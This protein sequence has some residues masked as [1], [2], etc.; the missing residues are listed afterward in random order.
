MGSSPLS[1]VP[2]SRIVIPFGGGIILG[3]SV[4]IL[5]PFVA[6]AIAIFG[7]GLLVLMNVLSRNPET[8]SKIRPF[9]IVPLTIIS[10]ALGWTAYIIHQPSPINLPKVNGMV[11][12]GRIENIEFKVHS[13]RI[14][15]NML[16]KHS[17][18]ARVLLTTNGCNYNLRAGDD[19]A[20]VAN[21]Q[22]IGNPNLGEDVDYA[23][24]LKRKG[25]IYQQH[26]ESKGIH[27]YSHHKTFGSV[28]AQFRSAIKQSVY[29]S[30][31]SPDSK[32]YI[33]ALILG[34]RQLIDPQTRIEYSY[35]GIAHVLALSGL[36]IGIIMLIA[37]FIFWP[38][39]FYKQK[40]LRY[41]L[42]VIV[43]LIYDVLTGLPP[44][45][46]RATV[47]IT[48]TFATFIFGRK[49]S[50]INALMVAAL[51]ILAYS[52]ESLFDVGF[53][54]SFITVLFILIFSPRSALVSIKK[55]WL[56]YLISLI[57]T[58]AIAMCATIALTAYYF[59][60]ISWVSVLTNTL[61]LPLFPVIMGVSAIAVVMA[62]INVDFEAL[63]HITDASLQYVSFIAQQI[64][65]IPY[66]FS[67]DVYVNEM[68]VI[69]YFACITLFFIF[70]KY[71]KWLYLNWCITCCAAGIVCH[72]LT[73][74]TFQR[75]GCVLFNSYDSTP[76]FIYQNGQSFCW[77]PD[78]NPNVFHTDEFHQ[79]H[80]GFFAAHC[81][82]NVSV[83]ND[84][85]RIPNAAF[86]SPYARV[87]GKTILVA[88]SQKWRKLPNS[89]KVVIDYCIV[90]RHFNGKISELARHY[91]IRQMVVSGNVYE[92]NI[93]SITSECKKLDIH[94]KN[95]RD[96][97][98]IIE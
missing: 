76:V 39:D 53:Q 74:N 23:K 83:A 66:S 31:L 33:I 80:S 79:L 9:T 16:S 81:I 72:A 11:A 48:F 38:L 26:I 2:F 40:K 1:K 67:K 20:F 78:D 96:K 36:H 64:S 62:C 59:H 35:A 93:A 75:K 87:F 47:M 21:F 34:D 8:R 84:S 70:V 91:I 49:S 29:K 4:N 95:L 6:I 3:N 14:I 82:E 51:I 42:S 56:N 41:I 15:T 92:P 7:C 27:N 97:S 55:K 52:P 86:R 77:I 88:G 46:I 98:I 5:S 90:T 19:I 12:F 37:W 17:Q 69:C 25:I 68:D 13:M 85:L 24:I 58:S 28:M 57:A 22:A 61:V 30:S 65:H 63:N 54:L 44:S 89:K 73:M 32:H 60:S 45:A 94:V 71:R 50:G 10:V 43:L 18:G